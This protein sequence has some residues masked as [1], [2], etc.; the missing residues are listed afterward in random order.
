MRIKHITLPAVAAAVA[1]C[2]GSASAA[3]FTMNFDGENNTG[4][5]VAPDNMGVPVPDQT[6]GSAVLGYYD[7]DAPFNRNGRQFFETTFSDAA[8]AICSSD[9][10][11]GDCAGGFPT[12]RSGDWVVAT[13]RSPSFDL[14]LKQGL[15]LSSASFYYSGNGEGS[16]PGVALYSG[17]NLIGDPIMLNECAAVWCEWKSA[18]IPKDRLDGKAITRIAFLGTPNKVVF[19][20]ITLSTSP[21]PE[22]SAHLL[23]LP[24]LLVLGIAARRSRR[25]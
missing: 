21:I 5:S 4:I 2:A 22:P 10:V 24:G 11:G 17:T 1:L 13:V 23:L 14:V 18:E 7:G 3:S 25:A 20:D 19:D 6:Y 8:L 15:V 12:A 9:Q 16:R